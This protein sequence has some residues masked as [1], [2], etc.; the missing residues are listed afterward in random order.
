MPYSQFYPGGFEDIPSH[1]TPM[2]AEFLNDLEAYLTS[3]TLSLV[4]GTGAVLVASADAPAAVKAIADYVCDGTADDV[5]IALAVADA[6]ALN[7]RNSLSPVGAKQRGKVQLT[8]GRFNFANAVPMYTGVWVQGMGYLTECKAVNNNDPGMF[9]LANPKAHLVTVSD[10]YLEGSASSGGTC[11]AIHFDM[12]DASP[13]TSGYPDTNPDA[14]H[15]VFNLWIHQFSSAAGRNGITM[16]GTG[17]TNSRG[18]DIHDCQIRICSGTSV[19]L[20]GASD[21]RLR[22]IHVGGALIGFDI[23]SGNIQIDNCKAYFCDTTAFSFTGSR[24]TAAN[25]ECQDSATGFILGSS[26]G[27]FANLTVD[28]F[29]AD[30]IKINS[31]CVLQGFSIYM[32]GGG[33]YATGARGLNI[34]SA[35]ADLMA[36][37]RIVPGSI[38]T[39]VSGTA[40]A[41]QSAGV[42]LN[43]TT[44]PFLLAH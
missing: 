42:V 3:L 6:A 1:D 24:T 9:V 16:T 4:T 44:S 2:T 41:T 19:E 32:R 5:Q 39:P 43:G 10:M 20:S 40:H 21:S 35:Q 38:T 34:G 30:G 29:S 7:S 15:H 11:D 22:G 12:T 33:R 23:A 14:D 31:A 8:G 37:G 26:N 27:N 17:S 28:T 25:L 13:S 18:Q 36:Y